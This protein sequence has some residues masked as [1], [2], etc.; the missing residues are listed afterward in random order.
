MLPVL[1]KF[2]FDTEGS[3]VLLFIIALGLVVYSA[4]SGWR[5]AGG[6]DENGKELRRQVGAFRSGAEFAAWLNAK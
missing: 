2:R 4:W 5:N 1:Y 6:V 3:R